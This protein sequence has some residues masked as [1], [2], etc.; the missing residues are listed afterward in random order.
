[1]SDTGAADIG[2]ETGSS[3]NIVPSMDDQAMT[4]NALAGSLA[5]NNLS[6]PPQL[7]NAAPDL[8]TKV[9]NQLFASSGN[10]S[11]AQTNNNI[12]TR[13]IANQGQLLPIPGAKPSAG[14]GSDTQTIDQLKQAVQALTAKSDSP[15]AAPASSSSSSSG[16]IGSDIG[17]IADV[18]EVIAWVICTELV[19]QG[20]MPVKWYIAGG[21][22]FAAYPEVGKRGYYIWAIPSVRHMR[23]HPDSYFTKFLTL[24]FLWRA[25]NI[26]ANKGVK[27]AR[28]LWRGAAVTAIL[29]PLCRFLGFLLWCVGK[30]MNWMQLYGAET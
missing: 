8:G 3:W 23:R 5:Q 26:A 22:V 16:G 27:G 29:Y 9:L 13:A 28:K 20:K 18:A 17:D 14:A 1:M 10:S 25:E 12:V 7:P 24:I 11:I 21:S 15:T 19:R 6:Q 30:D 4:M 2:D